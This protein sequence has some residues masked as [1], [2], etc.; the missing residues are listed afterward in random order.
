MNKLQPPADVVIWLGI[1]IVLGN[2]EVSIPPRK[3]AEIQQGLAD[4][5][6]QKTLT[7]K[8]LQ[9]AI[10]QINHFAKV[11]SPARLFMGR[12]LAALR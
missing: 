1:K 11:V 12:L 6:R 2:N 3:L 9:R 7:K 4:A 10:G 5:S 8:A